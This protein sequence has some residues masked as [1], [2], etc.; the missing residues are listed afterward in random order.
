MGGV[1]GVGG[2]GV[3]VGGGGG[4][5]GGVG[6]VVVV[7]GGWGG[8]GGGGWGGGGVGVGGGGGGVSFVSWTS[9]DAI[10]THAY[11]LWN[12]YVLQSSVARSHRVVTN[13]CAAIFLI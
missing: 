7:G 11:N 13:V 8:G 9:D 4:G 10:G 6:G 12:K 3:G 2:G 1:G 5:G